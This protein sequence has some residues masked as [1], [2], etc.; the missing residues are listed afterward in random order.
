MIRSLHS[1]IVSYE[2]QT[3]LKQEEERKKQTTENGYVEKEQQKLYQHR[4]PLQKL[5]KGEPKLRG[6]EL[7]AQ[8]NITF[9]IFTVY[10]KCIREIGKIMITVCMTLRILHK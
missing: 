7:A 10:K 9:I 2:K 8:I 3:K 4:V 1:L 5:N 6:K